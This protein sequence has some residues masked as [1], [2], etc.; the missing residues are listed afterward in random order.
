MAVHAPRKTEIPR[1]VQLVGLPLAIIGAWQLVSAVDHA[2]FVFIVAALIAI[3]LNPMVRAFCSLRIPRPVAV[4]LV[5]GLFAVALSGIAV[6]AATVLTDQ[7]RASASV[8]QDEFEPGPGTNITPADEKVDRIQSWLDDHGLSSVDVRKLGDDA[9]AKIR[10]FDLESHSGEAV[11]IAQG[12]VLTVFES[13]FNIVLVIV[14][15]IYMLLDADRLSRFLRRLFPGGSREDDLIERCERA[16]VSYVRGQTTVSLVIGASAGLLMWILG[17]LGIFENG[18]DYAL[19]FGA[20]AAVTE[21]IPYVGPWLGAIPPLLVALVQSP[22]AA[23]AVAL[24]FL[25]IH[26]IEGHIVIPKLMGGAVGVHPL[27][28]IFSLL[29]AAQLYGVAGVLVALPLVAV[30]REVALFLR[31]RLTLESWAGH[32]IPVGVPVEVEPREPPAPA[33]GRPAPPA[34]PSQKDAPP[35]ATES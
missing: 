20:F 19:A 25:I 11:G 12:L 31:E 8:V 23:I 2:V 6:V 14:I 10:D 34:E 27:V 28:V 24:A 33:P 15:S 30:G 35:D 3:L 17:V 13:L 1:W 32:P 18:D 26:Q 29:A 21:V 5:Y 22:G 9:I 7:V 4:F 16:L